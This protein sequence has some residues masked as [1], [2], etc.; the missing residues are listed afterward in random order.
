MPALGV[1]RPPAP[2]P[3]PPALF[4]VVGNG[5]GGVD[6]GEGD[7]IAK[8]FS[9]VVSFLSLIGEA[10]GVCTG[11]GVRTTTEASS[12]GRD[13]YTNEIFSLGNH[14]DPVSAFRVAAITLLIWESEGGG[15]SSTGD[16]PLSEVGDQRSSRSINVGLA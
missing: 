3:P 15:T 4:G 10:D 12:D 2:P 11:G 14:S 6:S 5:L 7:R 13:R 8:L 9:V 1:E 16:A